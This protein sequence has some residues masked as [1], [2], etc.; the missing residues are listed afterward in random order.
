MKSFYYLNGGTGDDETA[1]E[2]GFVIGN[3]GFEDI[4]GV[5]G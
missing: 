2:E 1:V 5:M 3:D 4:E